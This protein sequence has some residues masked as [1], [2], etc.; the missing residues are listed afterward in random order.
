MNN[1]KRKSQKGM[2]LLVTLAI[3][4]VLTTAALE[5]AKKTGRSAIKSRKS[6][7]MLVAREIAFSGIEL[8]KMLLI[9]DAE[10][11][12]T[13]SLQEIWADQEKMAMA[14]HI[15]GLAPE[16][17]ELTISDELGKIQINALLHEF[18][19]HEAN[20][21]QIALWE[22]FL[23][24]I[25][26]SDKSLDI[27]DSAEIINSIKDWLDSG[28]DDAI[29]GLS[30]AESSWY[31]SLDPPVLCPNSPMNRVEELFMIK[32]IP[33]DLLQSGA[34]KNPIFPIL[35]VDSEKNTNFTNNP[36]ELQISDYFTVYGMDRTE[37]GRVRYSWPGR[38][39]INT[40]DELILAAILPEGMEDQA[41]ELAEF[42]T[43]KGED[44][45]FFVNSLDREWYKE[46]IELS[47]K[48][49]KAFDNLIRY[50]S[51]LFKVEASAH[52]NDSTSVLTAIIRREK[53]KSGK[54]G[55]ITLQLLETK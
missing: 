6:A 52:F 9:R 4:A 25:I 31:A 37:K 1:I 5:V 7:D 2:A 48:E 54:W 38:I 23:N 44:G 32:G 21:V 3:I 8:A 53:N 12:D 34:G 17:L 33:L 20:E 10:Q 16:S 19:G 51:F 18:P 49:K 43:Q 14:P 55:C 39:N 42:R 50:D 28:D 29:S 36:N 27:R 40:A 26:S 30:G 15:L 47:E 45:I 13:D 24:L 46:V 22:R 35:H 11:G 41:G